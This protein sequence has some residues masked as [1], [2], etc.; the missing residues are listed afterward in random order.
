MK[1]AMQVL[2]LARHKNRPCFEDW[3]TLLFDDF[4]PLCGD[5][6]FADDE[7]LLGGIALLSGRPVTVLGHAKGRNTKENIR[8]NFGMPHPEGYRKALRLMRQAEKFG[9]P[10]I[11]MVDTPGAFCGIGAEERGQG[12]AIARNLMEMMGINTPILTVFTGEGGSG[13]ALGLAVSDQAYMMENAVYSVISPRGCASILWNDAAREAE[14]AEKLKM[15]A[16]DLLALGVIDAILPEPPGGAHK[17]PR[18]AADTIKASLL[19][20]LLWADTQGDLCPR[21]YKRFRSMGRYAEV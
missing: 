11:T 17:N 20:G 8:R 10:V 19:A 1:T 16:P 21:R 4:F 18:A 3:L 5:R 7:A 6:A 9:R 15:T 2:E 13:G 14:A 12:E